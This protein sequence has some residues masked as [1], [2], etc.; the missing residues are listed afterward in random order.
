MKNLR[1]HFL[2][3]IFL[4][5]PLLLSAQL[6]YQSGYIITND[7]DTIEGLVH[8]GNWDKNPEVV[9]FRKNESA[10][11]E[12]YR[13]SDIL[14]FSVSNEH[15]VSALVDSENSSRNTNSLDDDPNLHLKRDSAF[16]LYLIK[17]EKSL[18]SFKNS[19]GNE[20]FYTRGKD[21]Y[22]LLVYKRYMQKSTETQ[23]QY[24]IVENET[25][26]GQIILYLKDSEDIRSTA[27]K[28]RYT[29]QSLQGVF[30][31]YYKSTGKTYQKE[32]SKEKS[33]IEFG[34]LAGVSSTRL[35][36]SS[37]VE[38]D[39]G[40]SQDVVFG[41]SFEFYL[42]RKLNRL[43]INNELMY[44]QFS[45]QEQYEET[46]GFQTATS[47]VKLG[48]SYLKLNNMFRYRYP[49]KQVAFFVNIGISNAWVLSE[50]NELIETSYGNTRN[51]KVINDTRKYE[52]C[53][54]FG[55]GIRY[56]KFSLEGRYEL[57]NGMS[58]YTGL[59]T[60]TKRNYLFLAYAF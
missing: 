10:E 1:S 18:L 9:A 47:D 21:G 20:N 40:L 26:K 4:A 52:Q 25:F 55:M 31:D 48:Y 50:E 36:F 34:V 7:S 32:L 57:G 58:A 28:C 12:K 59:K 51:G 44:T 14:G 37:G 19:Y 30:K 60:T 6:N 23:N 35:I 33:K 29:K 43:S 17:G 3:G 2:V 13:P 11:L 42:P 27:Y 49:F 46:I 54:N 39:F 45:Y 15:Y 5:M 16:L 22:D 8:Y 24:S 38:H 53:I 41:G 56:K